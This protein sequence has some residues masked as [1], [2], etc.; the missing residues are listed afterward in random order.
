[1]ISI[2]VVDTPNE[3]STSLAKELAALLAGIV[4]A[5]PAY[6]SHTEYMEGLSPDGAGWAGDIETRYRENFFALLSSGHADKYVYLARQGGDLVGMAVAGVHANGSE[7]FW[8]IEDMGV[9]PDKRRLGVG[10]ALLDRIAGDARTAGACRL[11]LES[12]AGNTP[13]HALFEQAGFTVFSKV[14]TRSL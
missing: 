9:M 2:E 12:G 8:S 13:A 7:T 14:F 6:I 1:M 4:R 11:M 3:E 10:Q 5:D